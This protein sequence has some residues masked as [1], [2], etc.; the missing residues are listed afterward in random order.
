MKKETL[1]RIKVVDEGYVVIHKP[2]E[3]VKSEK[4]K[5]IP[6]EV[7]KLL[8]EYH[9]VVATNLPSSLPP[10]RDISHQID[11]IPGAF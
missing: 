9:G 6:K 10:I 8:E 7:Q 3:E 2:R 11:F 4:D 5:P 1:E